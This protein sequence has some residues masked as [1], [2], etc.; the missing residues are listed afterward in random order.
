MM[1]RLSHSSTD[2]I[3]FYVSR[4]NKLLNSYQ[5]VLYLF[6]YLIM[7]IY[8]IKT[9][10][11]LKNS[12]STSP[13]AWHNRNASVKLPGQFLISLHKSYTK[14]LL[15]KDIWLKKCNF[16]SHKIQ[17]PI[18]L[19]ETKM[20]QGESKSSDL[21]CKIKLIIIN[22]HSINFNWLNT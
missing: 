13:W 2:N 3:L 1:W 7:T 22:K 17:L 20:H 6:I 19:K 18:I 5:N 9:Q 11:R 12:V 4:R 10:S 14:N 15:Y 16:V 21:I 8:Q